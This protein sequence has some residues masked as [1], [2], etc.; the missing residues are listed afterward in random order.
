MWST[1]S[2]LSISVSLYSRAHIFQCTYELITEI[3]WRFVSL[4]TIR[5]NPAIQETMEV[6]NRPMYGTNW[7]V[8][9]TYS[10]V[11]YPTSLLSTCRSS[12]GRSP[13]PDTA[14]FGRSRSCRSCSRQS[15]DFLSRTSRWSSPSAIRGKSSETR[16]NTP[17]PNKWMVSGSKWATCSWKLRWNF[18]GTPGR[19]LMVRTC[20]LWA[21]M[22][23]WRVE[24]RQWQKQAKK[25]GIN[26]LTSG[27]CGCHFR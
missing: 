4:I 8:E 10:Y 2:F 12:C 27:R 24:M 11:V 18:S 25:H 23:P 26:S 3:L 9:Q 13:C 22:V 5:H 6:I 17:S 7:D 1:P 21:S 20:W 19:N 15:L 14:E 16:G